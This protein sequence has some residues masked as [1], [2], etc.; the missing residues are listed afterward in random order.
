MKKE[1]T[2]IYIG[3]H[4]VGYRGDRNG[5]RGLLY[6]KGDEV[7]FKPCDKLIQELYSGPCEHIDNGR[8]R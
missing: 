3:D 2:A 6:K 8:D 5:T 7:I 4:K 1:P